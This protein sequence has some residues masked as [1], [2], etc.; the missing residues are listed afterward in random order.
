MYN[1]EA[2]HM[3]WHF[4]PYA[5]PLFVGTAVLLVISLIAWQRR[6][7]RGA[8]AVSLLSA[9]TAVYTLGYA[10]ELGSVTLA[11]AEFWTH[12]EYIGITLAPV[13][14]FVLIAS[15]TGLERFLT[16]LSI[17][18]LVMIPAITIIFAW[19]ND[20][21][22]LLWQDL[23]L[24]PAG[25][26]YVI[27]FTPGLWYWVNV[28]YI[29]LLMVWGFGLLVRT[30]RRVSGLFRRQVG[31]ILTGTLIPFA[32][33][34]VFLSGLIPLELDITPYGL[35]I[36][37]L[38]LAW[39]IFNYQLLD[40]MPIARQTVL[41]GMTDAVIVLDVRDRVVDLNGPAQ[42]LIAPDR[43]G[44]LGQP[45]AAVFPGWFAATITP[46][47]REKRA[48]VIVNLAGSR[49]VFDMQLTPLSSHA[50]RFEGRLIVLHDMTRRK[51]VEE[52]RE[53]LLAELDA[54]A[55]TVAHDLK[56]PLTVILGYSSTLDE[57]P[58]QTSPEEAAESIG[59]IARTA[60]KMNSI[61]DELLL[62]SSVRKMDE[63]HIWPLKMAD[64][65]AEARERLSAMIQSSEAIIISPETW[66]AALGYPAWVEEVWTNYI[67]NAIKYGGTP[68][69]V[70]LGAT[71]QPGGMIR[72][73]VKDNGRGLTPDEQAQVFTEFARF[74]QVRAEG[75]GLGLSIVRRIVE[76][77]GGEVGVES[78]VGQGCE[79][80]FTLPA[81]ETEG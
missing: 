17:L 57:E 68:P 78:P 29:W 59:L 12:I 47:D 28:A 61:V 19:T 74:Q 80:Y 79:F 48:E 58:D 76:K 4:T 62:L 31:I 34:V 39:G 20:Q 24:K 69:R 9:T 8:L 38:V 1:S 33:H 3:T 42:T 49:R 55:R 51:Q 52:E 21:H 25:D 56:T 43:G 10:F 81:A 60:R 11:D 46:Q 50:G 44:Y 67:N 53:H 72:F 32:C 5:V 71:V 18:T 70:E 35:V 65:V 6:A 40:L 15:Y 64:I 75:Y 13:C 22:E 77:L 66:P 23:V 54:F 26:R 2:F 30:Y 36:V 45:A 73:W 7:V 27:D 63:V 14:L 41:A 37:S 16:P